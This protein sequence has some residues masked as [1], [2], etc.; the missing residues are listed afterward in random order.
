M[1]RV[2]YLGGSQEEFATHEDPRMRA[3]M[4]LSMTP[5]P[6]AL[7]DWVAAELQRSDS[8]VDI[9]MHALAGFLVQAH[10]GVTAQMYER[11][12]AEHCAAAF[13][14]VAESQYQSTFEA[15]FDGLGRAS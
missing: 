5:V 10:A 15:A 2:K 12:G 3:F 7:G 14:R 6:D 13:R 11:R 4:R 1:S 8:S 9:I